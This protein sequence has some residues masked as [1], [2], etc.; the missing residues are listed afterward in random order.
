ME[1]S[2]LPLNTAGFS[3]SSSDPSVVQVLPSGL[4]RSVGPAGIASITVQSDRVVVLL[5]VMVVHV[6]TRIVVTPNP[7]RVAIGKRRRL[8]AR[9]LDAMGHPMNSPPI[10]FTSSNPAL[11]EI[12]SDGVMTAKAQ[13][14][15]VTISVRARGTSVVENVPV[16]LVSAAEVVPQAPSP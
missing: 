15:Q 11:V 8:T 7:T 1:A 6:P 9:M 16:E 3:Y 2:G 10:E 12:A 13:L 5:Q 4:V 14:G